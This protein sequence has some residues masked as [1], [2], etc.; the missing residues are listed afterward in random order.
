MLKYHVIFSGDIVSARKFSLLPPGE[1]YTSQIDGKTTEI[2]KLKPGPKG[3]PLATIVVQQASFQ[4]GSI[5]GPSGGGED[6]LDVANTFTL[7]ELHEFDMK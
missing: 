3:R 4:R 7:E 6:L 1:I 2:I 5:S